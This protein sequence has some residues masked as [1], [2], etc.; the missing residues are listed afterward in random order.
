M[1]ANPRWPT[2]PEKGTPDMEPRP[3]HLIP[4]Y[5]PAPAA[6]P[7]TQ[8]RAYRIAEIAAMSGLAA[9]T[10][11]DLVYRGVLP[12]LDHGGR[13]VLVPAAA[14]DEWLSRGVRDER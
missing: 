8:R 4:L 9:K 7:A 3:R 2:W 5:S 1:A 6:R 13:A 12:R 10:V 11:Y 14:V